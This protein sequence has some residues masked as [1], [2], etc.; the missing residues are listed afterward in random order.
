MQ[1]LVILS[2]P[3]SMSSLTFHIARR[4]LGLREP[5]W[6]SDGE[7]LNNDRHILFRGDAHD[8]GLKYVHRRQSPWVC[9]QL[10]AFLDQVVQPTGF[11]YK[12]VVNPFVWA[13]WPHLDALAV[14]VIRRPVADVAYS[15][16][17]KDWRYPGHAIDRAVDRSAAD[18][19]LPLRGLLL[20]EARLDNLAARGAVQVDYDALIHDEEALG[21]ALRRLYP[22]HDVVVPRYID[23]SFRRARV[24]ALQRRSTPEYRELTRRLDALRAAASPDAAT[25]P[26][27][28]ARSEST[29]HPLGASS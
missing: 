15:V 22:E 12:D 10:A 28:D 11:A 21:D 16:V 26:P 1:S 4:A 23:A 19:D 13:D 18:S 17:R 3:R 9:D 5:E 2:L 29:L 25:F 27:A 6:T 7:I 24:Q 14:L 8:G 20:A